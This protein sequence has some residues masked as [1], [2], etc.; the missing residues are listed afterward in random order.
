LSGRGL[1][2]IRDSRANAAIAVDFLD[3]I[4]YQVGNEYKLLRKDMMQTNPHPST[5]IQWSMVI[6]GSN[7]E[8]L[9]SGFPK[10]KTLRSIAELL[11]RPWFQRAWVIQEFVVA[12]DVEMFVGRHK[13]NWVSFSVAFHYA[14]PEVNVRWTPIFK[15][16]EC[17]RADFCRGLA[18]MLAMH[19]LRYRFHGDKQYYSRKRLRSL[20]SECRAANATDAVDKIYALFGLSQDFYDY[21][22]DYTKSKAEVYLEVV[23]CMITRDQAAGR[24]DVAQE[25]LFEAA[26]SDKREEDLPSWVPDWTEVP[27][28]M[29]LGCSLSKSENNSFKAGGGPTSEGS[30]LVYAIDGNVL[31]CKGFVFGTLLNLGEAEDE[32]KRGRASNVA[33]ILT[34]MGEMFEVRNK[35]NGYP[36]GEDLRSVMNT[37]LEADQKRK[38]NS[39]S[40]LSFSDD[41]VAQDILLELQL[42]ELSEERNFRP[43]LVTQEIVQNLK[44]VDRYQLRNT[45]SA[46]A[47]RRFAVTTKAYAGL[48][49][50]AAQ[51]GDKIVIL[52]GFGVPL[53][54]RRRSAGGFVLIGDCY[55]HGIM[56]GEALRA[57]KPPVMRMIEIH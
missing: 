17:L 45:T 23:K 41:N 27:I 25:T 31:K 57:K 16:N 11:A 2:S 33:R 55:I 49:P 52:Q 19:D 36:T 13:C 5:L 34:V 50:T 15:D 48:V 47:G 12:R 42:E 8:K 43:D 10:E 46:I 54:M 21:K 22:T 14:F 6:V 38:I 29:N 32:A 7:S 56:L 9:F 44:A 28:R 18:Q 20:L 51:R 1:D 30:K 3:S 35:W 4:F 37:I 40:I 24:S 53:V 26:R 39:L